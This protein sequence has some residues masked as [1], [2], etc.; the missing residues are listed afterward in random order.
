MKAILVGAGGVARE[1]LRRL[2][3]SWEVTVVDTSPDRLAQAEALRPFKV[4]QGD[5]SSRVVLKR[6]GL[7]DADA[8]VAATNEDETNLEVCRIA[9]EAGVTRLAAVAADPEEAEKYRE[10]EVMAVSPDRLA[11]RTLER[12]LETRRIRSM[13]FAEG[14]A[15]A[16]EFRIAG[17]S[18]V[19]GKALKDLHASSF[20]VGAILRGRELVIPHGDTVLLAEDLVTVVGAGAQ[21]GEI[22][23]TFTSGEG[24]FPLDYGKRVAVAVDERDNL[25]AAFNEALYL[26][27]NSLAASLLLV[28]RDVE[29]VRDDARRESITKMLDACTSLA[30]GVEVRPRGVRRRPSKAVAGL[31]GE[32]SVGAIVVNAPR[33]GILA[34]SWVAMR[35]TKL[36]RRTGRPVLISRDSHP[37]GKILVLAKLDPPGLAAIRAATDLAR[38]CK[39]ELHGLAVGDPEFISGPEAPME[40]RRAISFME[41]EAAMQGIDVHGAVERGNPVRKLL[42]HGE[43]A[44]LIVLGVRAKGRRSFLRLGLGWYVARRAPKSILLVPA[45]VEEPEEA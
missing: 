32:E 19:C 30:E 27:R 6:A 15:E 18:V 14:R 42:E 22:V 21:F 11:A 28:H 12:S 45:H 5:G 38:F 2:G 34:Q 37:Y 39:A 33:G 17:D 36:V 20:I 7:D 29:A 41:E 25:D 10:L 3:T 8:V 43:N 40:A 16:I 44:D 9:R 13:A 26:V 23:R 31:A 4:V 1:L 24:R 35:A